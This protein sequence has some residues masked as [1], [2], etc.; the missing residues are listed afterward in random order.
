MEIMLVA[1]PGCPYILCSDCCF[2]FALRRVNT[3]SHE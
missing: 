1:A 3:F 2:H